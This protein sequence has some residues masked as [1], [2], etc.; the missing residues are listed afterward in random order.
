MASIADTCKALTTPDTMWS[1]CPNIGASI[2]FLVLFAIALVAH[3]GQAIYYKKFFN[4]CWVIVMSVLWQLLTYIFRTISI[5]T[6]ASFGDYAAWFV[7]VLI[8]PL[9]TNAFAYMVFGRLVYNYTPDRKLWGVPASRFGL[10]FVVLD[11]IAFV[12]QVYGAATASAN[13]IPEDEVLRDLHVYM[14]GV[15]VQLLFILICSVFGIKLWTVMRREA[16]QSPRALR[17]ALLLLYVQF[18]VLAL[19][20]IRIIFRIVEY[21]SGLKSSIPN[22]EAFQYALDTL[23]MFV[24][25][26]LYNIVHP[27]SIMRGP[28]TEMPSSWRCCSRRK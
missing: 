6:P 23:P 9:W 1:F 13:G 3:V 14:G 7:L 22:H 28:E 18:A 17:P 25:I 4:Y 12:I 11:I 2:F 10:L 19:I 27:G 26:V 16:K 21:A 20:I 8:A 24:A 15:G 5:Q